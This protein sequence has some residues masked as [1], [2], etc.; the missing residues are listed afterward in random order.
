MKRSI[1]ILSTVATTLLAAAAANSATCQVGV[2]GGVSVMELTND[3]DSTGDRTGFV[4]GAY[5][6]ADFSEQFGLRIEGLYF[7]KGAH[8]EE[9]GDEA[10][11]KLDYI[12]FP[13]LAVAHVPLG[14]AAR[15]DFFGGPTLGF[16]VKSELEITLGG[17]TASGDLDGVESFEFGVTLGAGVD[18]DAGPVVLGVDGRYGVG[19]TDVGSE[20]DGA[21]N[22]GFAVM[23]SIGFP[24]GQK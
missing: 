23:G 21:K 14:E 24:I 4:G 22:R 12:E 17:I 11:I 13:I 2:K 18:F 6:L 7:Q 3:G 15:L 9:D 20:G 8:E 1:L 16:N 19:I 10:T 5:L